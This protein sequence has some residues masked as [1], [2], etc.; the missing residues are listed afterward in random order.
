MNSFIKKLKLFCKRNKTIG[1]PIWE[2]HSNFIL[3]NKLSGIVSQYQFEKALEELDKEVIKNL[4]EKCLSFVQTDYPAT[5][6]AFIKRYEFI[7]PD[8][9]N[10][11]IKDTKQKLP[12]GYLDLPWAAKIDFVYKQKDPKFISYLLSIETKKPLCDI[13]KKRLDFCLRGQVE[14]DSII[15]KEREKQRAFD[16]ENE[17]KINYSEIPK[18]TEELKKIK[19][20]EK[21]IMKQKPKSHKECMPIDWNDMSFSLR[22]DFYRNITDKSFKDYVGAKDPKLKEYEIK[23]QKSSKSAFKLYVTLYAFPADKSSNETKDRI[24]DLIDALNSLGRGRLQYVETINPPLIEI[25]EVRS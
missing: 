3:K 19:V 18:E 4:K 9:W 2:L 7:T 1:V 10:E 17:D 24:K 14:L 5:H 21:E 8:F 22:L 6:K 15:L 11:I 13:I 12:D 16:A 23:S 25:R 20:P